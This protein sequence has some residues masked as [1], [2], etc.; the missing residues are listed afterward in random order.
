MLQIHHSNRLEVLLARLIE[1]L[2]EPLGDP[3][4]SERILVQNQG[5]ARWLAQG[6]ALRSGVAANLELPLPA[7]FVWELLGDWIDDLPRQSDWDA[8]RLQWRIYALLPGLLSRPGFE[9]PAGYLAGE[10]RDLKRLQLARRIADLFD[11]YLVYR[12]DLVLA[13]EAGTDGGEPGPEARW[14][15]D[16]WRAL[17]GE[18]ASPHRATL[19]ARLEALLDSG[20]SPRRP[21]PERILGFG[22]SALPP[23]YARLLARLGER[24]PVHLFLLSPS[25]E[26]WADLADERRRARARTRELIRGRDEG[27]GLLEVG[28]PLLA[29]WGRS[30]MAMQDLLLELEAEVHGAYVPADEGRLLGQIQSDLLR[31]RDRRQ[32]DPEARAT[33]ASDD[34]SIQVHACHGPHREVQVLHDRLLG[35]FET[36]PGLQP[37]DVIVMA[38]DIESYAPHVEAVFGSGGWSSGESGG[39]PAIPYSIA[40]RRLVAGDPLLA[41]VHGLLR[42]PASRLG[43]AEVLDWLALPAIARRFG[44]DEGDLARLRAWVSESGVRWG[45]DGEMRSRLDLPPDD[46]NTWSFGLERLFLGLSLPPDG[47]L[48]GAIAPYPDLEGPET[49]A[50]GGLQS[51]IDALAR[52]RADL[53]GARSPAHWAWDI[54]RLLGELLAPD[55][56]EETRLQPLRELLDALRTDTAAAGFSDPIGPELIETLVAKCLDAAGPAQRFLQGRVTFCNMVPMRSIPA[57]V[58]CLLGM[59][60]GAFPRQQHP[61]GFDLMTAHPRRGDRNRRE[62]DRLLFLETLLAARDRLL[63]F[64][65]GQD[66][67]DNALKVP[68]VLLTELLSYCSAAYRTAD[69]RDP[70]VQILAHHPLQPFSR[71]CF[72]G[73][74]PRLASYRS[75]W[76]RAAAA[77]REPGADRFAPE[78]LPTPRPEG[79]AGEPTG[80]PAAI[81]L[82]DLIGFWRS[83]SAWLLDRVVGLGRVGQ[84]GRLAESEPFVATTLE[85]WKIRDRVFRLLDADPGPTPGTTPDQGDRERALGTLRAE[86]LL[87]HGAAGEITLDTGLAAVEALR[88]RLAP[89]RIDPRPPLE[90]DL[91]LGTRRVTGWLDGLTGAGL[92]D[93]RVGKTRPTDRLRLWIRHLA[94]N[95]ARPAGIP[96]RSIL[97]TET[98]SL[99]LEP[100][101]D[102]RDLL[103][104]LIALFEQGQREPL[105]F[106]ASTSFDLASGKDDQARKTWYGDRQRAGECDEPANRTCFRGRDPLAGAEI[107][108]TVGLAGRVYGPLLRALEGQD[109]GEAR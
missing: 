37:R 3:F 35:L 42:L 32:P 104:D 23:V 64:Y 85:G 30:G 78:P 49:E 41:A 82:D 84:D 62:D 60:D 29:S 8:D 43:A 2:D 14:Q 34:G 97:I 33:L 10:P 7:R 83:P 4:V 25:Q 6:I 9:A 48:F 105:P 24:V 59:G 57:R 20:E 109:E 50:L 46:A 55:E 88:E 71:R 1:I 65:V 80:E 13:W 52:W 44:L 21:L 90:L 63:I 15:G 92:L 61:P 72:D 54:N 22:L 18:I 51:F 53:A 95:L 73:S 39:A 108:L 106:F 58:V 70:V 77:V 69:G 16:L 47:E 93:H 100:V 27:A 12:P 96:C 79:P 86:G 87:P 31:L 103:L 17:A 26:Y 11:Q 40:D 67:R 107:A 68:S 75:D 28:N 66:A 38:P 5:M 81:D 45:L 102:A 101:A 19:L 91:D 76:C 56:D 36:L 99:E 98:D 74:D 89:H 94:L